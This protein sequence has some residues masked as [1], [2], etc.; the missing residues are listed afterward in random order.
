MKQINFTKPGGFPL[1]QET[2]ARLQAAFRTELFGALKEQWGIEE[3]RNYIISKPTENKIGWA[4]IHQQS[5]N[6]ETPGTYTLQG[7]LYPIL[8]TPETSYLKTKKVLSPLTFGTGVPQNVYIDYSAAYVA[9]SEATGVGITLEAPIIDP[10]TPLETITY[11]N[12]ATFE[13]LASIP[14]ILGKF[15]PLDGS[16]A[17]EGDLDL[18]GHQLSNLDT[19]PSFSA[20]VRSADFRLG[21][22]DRR[23]QLHPGDYLGRALVD[24]STDIETS[25]YLNYGSD[26]ENT[27]ID[28]KLKLNNIV[29]NSSDA[30][31]LLIDNSGFVTK[32]AGQIKGAV[33]LGL[34][35]LW[36]T[37]SGS[38][39]S[40]WVACDGNNTSVPSGIVIPNLVPNG[41]DSTS[42]SNGIL[43]V[44]YIIYIGNE[45]YPTI[46]AG[47][48]QNISLANDVTS[49]NINLTGK[50]TSSATIS[51]DYTWTKI[52]GPGTEIIVTPT[53]TITSDIDESTE[54]T[55]LDAGVHI[56]RITVETNGLIITDEVKVVVQAANLA[57]VI[58]SCARLNYIRRYDEYEFNSR[59]LI[60]NIYAVPFEGELNYNYNFGL[61]SLN[62]MFNINDPDGDN[63]LMTYRLEPVTGNPYDVTISDG[64][65]VNNEE[66]NVLSYEGGLVYSNE[67]GTKNIQFN[68]QNLQEAIQGYQFKL[69]ITDIQGVSTEKIITVNVSQTASL[70][71]TSP[72]P[73]PTNPSSHQ[74]YTVRVN[75]K[76]DEVVTINPSYS[77]LTLGAT[78]IFRVTEVVSGNI[79]VNMNASTTQGAFT[80]EIGDSGYVDLNC[81]VSVGATSTSDFGLKV[82]TAKLTLAVNSTSVQMSANYQRSGS[83]GGGGGCFDVE[84]Y[85]ALANGRS[86]KLKNIQEG[87]EL[88]GF[89]FS[90][91]TS[92]SKE[93]TMKWRGTLSD[94]T[95]TNVVVVK[96]ESLTAVMYYEI[97][98]NDGKTIKVTGDHPL[99]T[100]E[101]NLGTVLRWVKA[102]EVNSGMYLIDRKGSTKLITSVKL[103]KEPL[104]VAVLD[105][106]SVD[107]YVI[108]DVVAHN[109][110]IIV[111]KEGTFITKVIEDDFNNL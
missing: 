15:L 104:E 96:K 90:N 34:I 25:L 54:I 102:G 53:G 94:A 43:N 44:F 66:I 109:A 81:I 10:S 105:V 87:D 107:N 100:S 4:I 56:F 51:G 92:E 82:G 69:I 40:G 8:I 7:I 33:P 50:L 63:D 36:N 29:A 12:L 67:L 13:T 31:P 30:T 23:G 37:S 70:R 2:F 71:I 62:L 5:E 20:K 27:V 18:G 86:K 83:T 98:T 106:E 59:L 11:Y 6:L 46:S 76:Q 85:V 1:E 48:D 52:S 97:N 16:K 110:E 64:A 74:S 80:V 57:P 41:I 35:A 93:A 39:P 45:D 21:H 60:D 32:G 47:I 28:G 78:G 61:R 58:N 73:I 19:N 26:W 42:P 79:K 38:I 91:D 55:N 88:V 77:S 9:T 65:V 72:S 111:A 84:T 3:D 22:P 17:M 103:I 89:A 99:L 14:D 95:K 49:V 75:G 24:N 108:G 101:N 68:I